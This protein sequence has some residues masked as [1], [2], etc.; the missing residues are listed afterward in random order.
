MFVEKIL[1]LSAK[2]AAKVL[3]ER[4][5]EWRAL[6]AMAKQYD[7]WAG[8]QFSLVDYSEDIDRDMAVNAIKWVMRVKSGINIPK[9]MRKYIDSRLKLLIIKERFNRREGESFRMSPP[10]QL[11]LFL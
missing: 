3:A 10:N 4:P 6:K 11:E 1:G 2:Q 5:E 7:S 8:K 9:N